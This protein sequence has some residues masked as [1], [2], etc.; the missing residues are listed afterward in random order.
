MNGSLQSPVPVSVLTGFLGAGKTSLLSRLLKDEGL[1]DA[2][3]IINELGEIGLDHALVERVDGDVVELASGCLCCTVRSDLGETLVRLA[4][5]RDR[6]VIRPFDRV[7]IETTGLADPAPILHVLMADPFLLSRFRLDSVVTVV[8]AFNGA[9]TLDEHPEAVKQVAVADRLV[10]TKADLMVGREGEDNLH[11]IVRRLRKLNPTARMLD[12]H[13]GEPSAA[14]LFNAGLYDPA[15][16]SVDVA[17]WLADAAHEATGRGQRKGHDHAHAAGHEDA[18]G[19]V[20][21]FRH[22]RDIRSF[23]IATDRAISPQGLEMFLDLLQSFHGRNL[24]R[25]KAIVKLADDEERPVVLHAVQHLSHPPYRMEKWP[26]GDRRSRLVFV[27]RGIERAELEK[28]FAAFTDP[29]TGQGAA[30]AD[31]TLSL[32]GFGGSGDGSGR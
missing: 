20:R 12:T 30:A 15:T 8:D 7:V 4:E 19:A 25:M 14:R 28:L 11:A 27:T 24:L 18:T 32:R 9:A 23:A 29:L 2:V 17:R 13:S 31:S 5:Q 3:V 10:L 1:A 6:G 22:D 16:K 21:A 26:D